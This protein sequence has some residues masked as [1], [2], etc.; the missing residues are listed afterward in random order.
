[1]PK[2]NRAGLHYNSLKSRKIDDFDLT[3][4]FSLSIFTVFLNQ[5][6]K[7]TWL[8]SAFIDTDTDEFYCSLFRLGGEEDYFRNKSLKAHNVPSFPEQITLRKDIATDGFLDFFF[9]H[10]FSYIYTYYIS[11]YIFWSCFKGGWLAT[12]SIPSWIQPCIGCV[13][14]ISNG[15]RSLWS[16]LPTGSLTIFWFNGL[17]TESEWTVK[18]YFSLGTFITVSVWHCWIFSSFPVLMIGR[19]VLGVPQQLFHHVVYII[20]S[21]L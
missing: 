12:Q 19:W 16:K 21:W 7:I 17:L 13:L 11:V 8:L 20:F 9:S 14:D 3:E 18:N 15:V 1:M 4:Q 2:N 10:V 5:S 6:I